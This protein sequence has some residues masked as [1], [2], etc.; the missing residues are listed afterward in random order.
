M[1]YRCFGIDYDKYY[2]NFIAEFS[3]VHSCRPANDKILIFN[4][5][6]DRESMKKL[7]NKFPIFYKWI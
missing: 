4:R 3:Q 1:S 7:S 2:T 5:F 6:V